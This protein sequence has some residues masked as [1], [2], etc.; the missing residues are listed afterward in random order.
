MLWLWLFLLHSY[1]P[2]TKEAH[3]A[4]HPLS[5][6]TSSWESGESNSHCFFSLWDLVPEKEK[7]KKKL[8]L[9]VHASLREKSKPICSVDAAAYQ[10]GGGA[11]KADEEEEESAVVPS[12]TVAVWPQSLTHSAYCCWTGAPGLHSGEVAAASLIKL[13]NKL[14]FFLR[15]VKDGLIL[16]KEESVGLEGETSECPSE[17]MEKHKGKRRFFKTLCQ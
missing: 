11:A 10:G 13:D 6:A 15:E 16:W 7:K 8:E 3:N 9:E 17:G 2:K 12:K 14:F 5:L 4:D 1:G